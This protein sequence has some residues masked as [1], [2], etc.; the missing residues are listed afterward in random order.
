MTRKR[1]RQDLRA[2]LTMPCPTC[3]GSGVIKSDETLAAEIFRAVQAKAAADRRRRARDRRVH[4]DLAAYLEGE[5]PATPWSGWP[6]ALD[7]KITRAGRDRRHVRTASE[8][9]GPC[10]PALMAGDAAPRQRAASSATCG[11]AARKGDRAA[12]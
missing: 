1:V 10:R 4:P 12:L 6:A 7:R 9:R 8:S 3:R 11:L 5:A 2:L